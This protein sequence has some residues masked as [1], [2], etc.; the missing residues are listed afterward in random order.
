M[1]K[2]NMTPEQDIITREFFTAVVQDT[3]LFPQN[4]AMQRSLYSYVLHLLNYD[5]IDGAYVEKGKTTSRRYGEAAT[6][7]CE[8]NADTRRA[9]EALNE[10]SGSG[11][12]EADSSKSSTDTEVREAVLRE[13][14]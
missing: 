4:P 13:D 10:D 9:Q 1:A 5:L 8:W 14:V 12:D 2:N 3:N 11:E 7:T 6:V